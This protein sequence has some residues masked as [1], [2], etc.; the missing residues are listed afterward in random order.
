MMTKKRS[1]RRDFIKKSA[2]IAG[3]P[4]IIPASILGQNGKTAPSNRIVVGGIGLGPRG[5]QVLNAFFKQSDFQ[6]VAIA[7]PQKDR[8][9][10]IKRMTDRKYGNTDCQTYGD[11]GDILS[12]DDIDA[13]IIATGDRWHSTATIYAARAGKDIYCEKPCAMNI[14]EAQQLDD[15]VLKHKRIF[16]AGTQRRNVPNFALAVELARSGQLGKLSAVHAG[17]LK[18]TPYKDYLP[19]QPEPDPSICDWDKWLGPAPKMPYNQ[20]YTRGKWRNQKDL[21]A[22]W[23]LPE[24]GAHTIDICQWAADADGTCPVEYE[25]MGDGHIEAKYSNGTKLVMRLAGFKGEGDW[26][27]GLGSCP[28]RFEGDNGWVEAGD[29]KKIVASDPK[30]IEGKI[31][32][33]LAGTDPVDHTRDFLDCVKSRKAPKCNSTAA[34]YAHLACFAAAASWKLDRKITFDPKSETFVNDDEATKLYEYTRRAPY[35][36]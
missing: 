21:Y 25:S 8:R 9:E 22:A 29:F 6:F 27:D 19:A 18:L 33:Q 10:V 7:D 30:L 3:M 23:R 14:M 4:M 12:R 26:Q 2:L 20:A 34:R 11:M 15:E 5:R 17:I 1:S 13:V 35:T 24:W 31:S 16:Q 32:N 36:I 28:V